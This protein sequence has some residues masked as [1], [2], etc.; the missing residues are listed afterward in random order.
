MKYAIGNLS[1]TV[2]VVLATGCFSGIDMNGLVYAFCFSES[3]N[4]GNIF[5]IAL[6]GVSSVILVGEKVI[7]VFFVFFIAN[8]FI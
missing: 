7:S 4:V 1:V 6:I 5:H 2:F 8:L 3:N